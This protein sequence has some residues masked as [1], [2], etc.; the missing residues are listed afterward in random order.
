MSAPV[1]V[2][3]WILPDAW[4]SLTPP[5]IVL[6]LGEMPRAP[7]KLIA[8][9][10]AVMVTVAPRYAPRPDG[11][12]ECNIALSDISQI[13][14]APLPHVF[15]LGDGFGKRELRANDVVDGLRRSKFDGWQAAGKGSSIGDS[16]AV[17]TRASLGL[18]TVAVWKNLSVVKDAKG[19]PLCDAQGRIRYHSGH[20]VYVVPTPPGAVGVYVTGAGA[21]CV[22][23]CPIVQ[24]FGDLL[25]QVEFYG[26]D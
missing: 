8:A 2:P 9:T 5:A 15:D 16:F 22:Q 21:K 25:P 12:T 10:R 1:A 13:L 20:V 18:P 24:A 11:S 23:E 7:E 3:P 26:H 4:R 14:N 19:K 17:I 6:Q